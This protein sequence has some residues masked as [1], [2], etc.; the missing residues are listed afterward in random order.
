MMFSPW[1]TMI[2]I[3]WHIDQFHGSITPEER[4]QIH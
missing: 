2:E 3:E 4:S 1:Q